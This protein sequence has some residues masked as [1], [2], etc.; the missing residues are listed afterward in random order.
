MKQEKTIKKN[1]QEQHFFLNLKQHLSFPLNNL[2]NGI[3]YI[4]SKT[5]KTGQ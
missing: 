3:I 4:P 5:W 1:Q 2:S